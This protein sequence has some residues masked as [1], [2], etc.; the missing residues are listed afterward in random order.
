MKNRQHIT[1]CGADFSHSLHSHRKVF[2]NVWLTNRVPPVS[3]SPRAPV[4]WS[5]STE[6]R[7]RPGSGSSPPLERSEAG[8]RSAGWFRCVS[9]T[10]WGY[11]LL[12]R[13]QRKVSVKG[14]KCDLGEKSSVSSCKPAQSPPP[15]WVLRCCWFVSLSPSLSVF[16][17]QLQFI[18]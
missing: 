10:L 8:R 11:L 4:G 2:L 6:P 16:H 17:A 15:S 14:F 12:R 13:P 7:R 1:S 9:G 5:G 3:V 18:C